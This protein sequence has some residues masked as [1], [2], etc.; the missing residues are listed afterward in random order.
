MSGEKPVPDTLETIAEQIRG[1]GTRFDAVDR[2]FDAVDGRI[3]AVDRRF[4]ELK[5]QLRTEIEVV[6]ADVRLVYEAVTA[7]ETRN[8][9]NDAEHAGFEQSLENHD[10]RILA[11][12][13]PRN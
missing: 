8:T 11:L 3:D 13:K 9:R 4:D 5:A 1:L 6:R 12:E 2:R 7:Q 10:L